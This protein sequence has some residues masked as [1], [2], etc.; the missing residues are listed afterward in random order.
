[1]NATNDQLEQLVFA[2]FVEAA[3]DEALRTGDRRWA[4][5]AFE[6]MELNRAASL[7]ESLALADAWRLRT[8]GEYWETLGR[9]RLVESKMLGEKPRSSESQRLRL[10][11]AE[12]EAKSGLGFSSKNSEIFRGQSSLIHFQQGLGRSE[13]LLSFHLG[14][15]YSYR[16]ELTPSSFRLQRIAAKGR[17]REKILAF[18]QALRSGRTEADELGEELYNE[19]FAGLGQEAAEGP[20]WLLSV[21]GPLFQV[22]FAALVTGRNVG[23]KTSYLVTKHSVQTIPGAL[24]LSTLPEVGT[25]WFLG[26]GDP[27]YNVADPR[28][29][30]SSGM[31]SFLGFFLPVKASGKASQFGRLVGSDAE[32]RSSASNWAGPA[33]LLEGADANR[34]LFLDQVSRS[35]SLVHLAT[36]VVSSGSTAMIALSMDRHAE[37]E[38]L[39]MAEVSTLHV[40]GAIVTMT[41]CDS[42]GGDAVEGAGLVGL[43]RAWE[44][45]GAGAVV[46]T[47]WPV[48]DSSGDVLSLFYKDLRHLPAAEALRQS[49]VEMLNSGTWR[50]KPSYWAA[51]QIT[52]GAR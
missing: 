46:A 38:F 4:E 25:G 26:I 22:P 43:T 27:I 10:E 18:S 32:L 47:S 52:G 13:V 7:R 9:L 8:P 3:A 2:S 42:G 19:L 15:K 29:R 41:G 39:T 30:Q 31:G 51:Y 48:L 17:I 1:L 40:P 36:H 49:Q 21:E 45:A 14:E 20:S 16:W 44:M 33:V 23:G 50:A 5:E 34:A 11:L 37:V 6:A 12:M 28:W 35:P 24:L